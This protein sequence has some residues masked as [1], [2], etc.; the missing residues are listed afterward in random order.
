MVPLPAF[1]TFRSVMRRHHRIVV[2]QVAVH[3]IAFRHDADAGLLWCGLVEDPTDRAEDVHLSPQSWPV[4]RR[5]P[6]RKSSVAKRR[7]LH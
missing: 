7:K 6:P 4:T 5:S 3:A 2:V 1:A